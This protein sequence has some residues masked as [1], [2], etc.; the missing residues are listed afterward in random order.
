MI[1]PKGN[2]LICVVIPRERLLLPYFVDNR[3][4]VLENLRKA[5]RFGGC[6]QIPGCRVDVN[7][8]ALCKEFLEDPRQPEWLLFLDNDNTFPPDLGVRLA[9][10]EQPIVGGLYFRIGGG[11][12]PH[13]YRLGEMKTD[14]YGRPAQF[15]QS[16]MADVYEFLVA[17]SCPSINVALSLDNPVCNPLLECDA[18]GTGAMLIHRSVLEQMAPP[19]FEF[20]G[21]EGED[22]RFC[23]RAKQELGIP[24]FVDL[25]AICGHIE[26]VAM[27][28]S[29]FM[30]FYSAHAIHA[31][32]YNP[33][34][35]VQW[36]VDFLGE[37]AEEAKLN[38]QNYTPE[39]MGDLWRSLNP[40]TASDVNS[41][42]RGTNVGRMYV[43]E[44]LNWNMT[45]F[46]TNIR[47]ELKSY[48]NQRVLEIGCGIGTISI[49]MAYQNCDVTAVEINPTLRHFTEKR[50]EWLQ[51]TV[52]I[53]HNGKLKICSD[54]PADGEFDLVIATD[55]FE[56]I[57]P[58]LL[59][60]MLQQI[61]PLVPVRGRIFHH[62]N[63]GQQD[64]FPF[65]YD[66]S[67]S[68]EGWLKKAGFF[69][70]DDFWSIKVR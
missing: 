23:K 38:L 69:L 62:N 15:W 45:E 9:R 51:N 58:K 37:D 10:W 35:A 8:N 52:P 50:W 33:D 61:E 1:V 29:Q 2:G 41:F 18:I 17:N 43:Y 7:R 55:V 16:M 4:M 11:Y 65:H 42:Y 26:M 46:F 63:W 34:M 6:V 31:S 24:I 64:L 54:I 70:L 25:S 5:D 47:S 60:A 49:Q 57:H 32:R 40:Q 21:D 53:H 12:T 44:L 28:H 3:D 56:H 66:H 36:L 27:G 20:N 67:S 14:E 59:P 39:Q 48:K 19:W 13:V 68:W 30:Q 22:L